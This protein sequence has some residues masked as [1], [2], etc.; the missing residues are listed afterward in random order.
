MTGQKRRIQILLESEQHEALVE[1]AGQEGRSISEIVREIIG[2]H[3]KERARGA[4]RRHAVE[5][6]ERLTGLREKI[7]QRSGVYQGDVIAEARAERYEQVV[8]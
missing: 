7:E 2:Q 4:K 5:A 6:L 8:D 1:I 3:L